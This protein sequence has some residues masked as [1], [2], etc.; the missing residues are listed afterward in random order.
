MLINCHEC[1]REVSDTAAACP[2][3]GAKPPSGNPYASLA[4]YHDPG[5]PKTRKGPSPVL[6][7]VGLVVVA[8]VALA[9]LGSLL[10]S[11][12]ATSTAP[13]ANAV[14]ASAASAPSNAASQPV[15]TSWIYSSTQDAMQPKPTQSACVTSS[16]EVTLSLPYQDTTANFCIRDWPGHGLDTYVKL[17]A[18]GQILCGI[19]SCSVRVRFDD[20]GVETFPAVGAADNASNIIFLNRTEALIAAVK[21]SSKMTVELTYYQNGDQT[22][23]FDTHALKWAPAA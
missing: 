20:G 19:E 2:N 18:D 5:S 4:S 3:C 14:A 12:A 17:N 23:T 10:P 6:V 7:I 8:V 15:P 9:V 13:A 21:R 22:L 16:N 11:P 1:G